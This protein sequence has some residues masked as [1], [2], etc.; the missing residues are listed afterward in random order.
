[1][2]TTHVVRVTLAVDDVGEQ[3]FST[4][5]LLSGQ[6]L[7][8]G[9]HIDE[10]RRRAELLGY[11]VVAVASVSAVSTSQGPPPAGARRRLNVR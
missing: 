10:A 8:D 2:P 5:I 7:T 6:Q 4:L 11:R 1:M 9:W 3:T